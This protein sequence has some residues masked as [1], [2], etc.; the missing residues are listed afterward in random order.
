MGESGHELTTNGFAGCIVS[1]RT[2][3]DL[4]RSAPGSTYRGDDWNSRRPDGA[5]LG[6]DYR[7]PHPLHLDVAAVVRDAI[8]SRR[9][10]FMVIDHE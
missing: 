9:S 7:W 2:R 3:C 1:F 4:S 10:E 8:D 5:E 6:R